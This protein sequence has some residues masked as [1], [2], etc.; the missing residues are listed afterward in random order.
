MRQASVQRCNA[1][2][3]FSVKPFYPVTANDKD[4]HEHFKSVARDMLGSRKILEMEPLMGSEDFSFYTEV[5]P[6]YFYYVGMEDES[7]GKMESGHSPYFRLNEDALP[8]GAALH[9]AL[10]TRYILENQQ[11][12]DAAKGSSHDE[13]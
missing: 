13:L 3:S 5:I 9:V 6:G 7:L 12:S 8:Y 10:A 4:L 1:T 2:V 11:K